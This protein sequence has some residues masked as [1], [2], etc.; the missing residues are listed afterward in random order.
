MV[1]VTQPEVAKGQ[2][3]WAS[4]PRAMSLTLCLVGMSPAF[5]DFKTQ[6]AS[7]VQAQLAGPPLPAFAV[8]KGEGEKVEQ[9]KVCFLKGSTT[10]LS[11][12]RLEA[13]FQPP[14]LFSCFLP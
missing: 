5:L 4:Y 8:Y 11:A 10:E 13:S 1:K 9:R 12:E 14:S 2:T 6:V 7:T 3:P